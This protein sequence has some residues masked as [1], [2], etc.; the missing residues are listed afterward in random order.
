MELYLLSTDEAKK[1]PEAFCLAQFPGRTERASRLRFA[2]ARLHCLGA[3]ALLSGA[4]GLREAELSKGAWGKPQ[5]EGVHFNLSH[6]GGYIALAVSRTEVGVDVERVR[7]SRL[8]LADRV[9]QPDELEWMRKAPLERFFWL[10]TL[11]ESVMKAVG[12]GLA[13]PP[14]QINVLPLTRGEPIRTETCVLYGRSAPLDGHWL[15]VCAAEP[16]E[17]L[18]PRRM[19]AQ[20]LTRA[21]ERENA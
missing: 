6:S 12:K 9:L 13:L 21:W 11:K 8:R 20:E 10:W 7:P 5:A 18:V 15:S 1:L 3:G 17:A 4:A 2:E 16:V 19:T 14:R